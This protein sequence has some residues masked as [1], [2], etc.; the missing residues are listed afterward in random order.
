MINGVL[1]DMDG[2][3]VDAFPPIIRAL[4]QTFSEFGLPQ[5]TAQEV[6]RH[7]G[8]GDC[9][10]KA[11][12]GEHR[13]AAGARF[14]EIHDEDYLQ[15]I[16]PLQG[17]ETLLLWLQDNALP[18]AIVTSKSQSRAE[19]Q[20]DILGWSDLVQAVIGKIEGRPEKPDPAP[21]WLACERLGI[22]ATECV[23]VGD[24]VADMQAATRAGSRALG[25]CD[26]FSATELTEAGADF[27]FDSL[28]GVHAWLKNNR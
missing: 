24:G 23:M 1:L 21:L 9:G 13:E 14:L 27:C 7:T 15:R 12:F 5:M 11:L 18:C 17:A 6:K 26:G 10:M 4:N 16:T 19:A 2:T 20:L 3:L 28:T 25:L 8:R 22:T